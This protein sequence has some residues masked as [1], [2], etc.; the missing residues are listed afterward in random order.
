MCWLRV[1]VWLLVICSGVGERVSERVS[2]GVKKASGVGDQVSD[3]VSERVSEGVSGVSGVSGAL[4]GEAL[5]H[6]ERG[7]SEC[8]AGRLEEAVEQLR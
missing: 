6:Y 2:E 7:V 3:R 1:S 8:E 4:H 5:R